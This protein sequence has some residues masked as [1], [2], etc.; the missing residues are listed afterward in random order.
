ME[1]P[2]VLLGLPTMGSINTMLLVVLMAW[3]SDAA[4]NGKYNLA[5]YPTYKVT[6]VDNA[7]NEVVKE[8]LKSDC[9]HI[10]W[11]DADTVP[12][13]DALEKLLKVNQPIVSA[14]TAIIEHDP[15]LKNDSNGFYKKWN[16]V[17]SQTKIH[18]KPNTGVLPIIGAGG[19]CILVKRSVYEKLKSPWYRTLYRDD[20]GKDCLVGEDISFV[21]KAVGQ[22]FAAFADTSIICAHEKSI[23][24]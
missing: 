12:P 23:L 7:R 10:M 6:P 11:I 15:N 21:A 18:V 22:G 8:F 20:K 5:I 3:L 24:W 19:S 9:S 4:R 14:L 16:A 17:S 13:I 2:K 1:K